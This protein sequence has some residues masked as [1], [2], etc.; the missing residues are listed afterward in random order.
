MQEGSKVPSHHETVVLDNN[1]Q[2]VWQHDRW[3]KYSHQNRKTGV[4][5]A[6][7]HVSNLV[8]LHR[9]CLEIPPPVVQ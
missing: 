6:I 8:V 2:A 1:P 5:L 9:C 7:H 3:G 4:L